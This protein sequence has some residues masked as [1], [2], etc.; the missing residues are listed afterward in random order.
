MRAFSVG[1]IPV[2]GNWQES[3]GKRVFIHEE[4]ELLEISA[5]PVPSNRSA[6]ARSKTFYEEPD[7]QDLKSYVEDKLNSFSKEISLLRE[8]IENSLEDIKSLLVPGSDEFADVLLSGEDPVESI[9]CKDK[10]KA[11]QSLLQ[12]KNA[13]KIYGE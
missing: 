13:F 1:F 10:D 11:G 12:I 4:I 3:K 8:S 2:K 9:P 6:L 7:Q 5:V